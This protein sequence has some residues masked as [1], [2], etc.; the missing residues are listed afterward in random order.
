[1]AD[2]I[3]IRRDSAANWTAEDPVLA[4]GEMGWETDTG[5]VKIGDGVT[6]WTLLP[7]GGIVGPAGP[8]GSP[9]TEVGV[10]V[11]RTPIQTGVYPAA[12][13]QSL[14]TEIAR[15]WVENDEEIELEVQVNETSVYSD[16]LAAGAHSVALSLTLM[17][18]DQV[19]FLVLS[20]TSATWLWA[21]IDAGE[22]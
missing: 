5:A 22:P 12:R 14:E 16:T 1:M 9:I 2:I 6:E 20:A 7:Y 21:Q 15:L 11:T 4:H 8:A 18:L 3:Q 17:P 10:L 19:D 13:S